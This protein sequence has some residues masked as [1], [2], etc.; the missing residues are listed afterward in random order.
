MD[1]EEISAVVPWFELAHDQGQDLEA[2]QKGSVRVFKTHAWR[3]HCPAGGKYIVIVRNPADVAL[4][5]YRFFENWFFQ[6][7]EVDLEPFVREFWLAR[8]RPAD[9]DRMSNA[10]FYDHFLSWWE[11]RDN[12]NVLLLF[13]EDMKEDLPAQVEKVAKFMKVDGAGDPELLKKVVEMSSFEFMKHHEGHF[14]EK[15]SKQS[16]NAACGLAPDAGMTKSKIAGP[17]GAGKKLALP[18]G[19]V[20]D[21]DA[22]WVRQMLPA[23]G[24]DSYQK[25]R[26][27]RNAVPSPN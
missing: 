9:D 4:S 18:E 7:G 10:S 21:I 26:A 11:V 13:F 25:L 6:P 16:R 5:F 14:D 15:L 2:P 17:A 20:A 3:D 23:T 27:G 1:F 19:L 24:Y 8:G 22:R 12:P